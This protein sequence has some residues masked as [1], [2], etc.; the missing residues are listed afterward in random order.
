MY[1]CG[2]S[3]LQTKPLYYI[4]V[5]KMICLQ[6]PPNMPL[7]MDYAGQK[8]QQTSQSLAFLT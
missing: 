5:L 1:Y 4:R 7:L 8:I 6:T 3:V 2:V